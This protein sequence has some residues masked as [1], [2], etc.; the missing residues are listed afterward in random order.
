MEGVRAGWVPGRWALQVW[1]AHYQAIVV[2]GLQVDCSYHVHP[3]QALLREVL[4]VRPNQELAGGLG[5]S[6]VLRKG[7][8]TEKALRVFW[9]D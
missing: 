8:D 1:A 4:F 2:L 5:G 6:W 3:H 7:V 9:G